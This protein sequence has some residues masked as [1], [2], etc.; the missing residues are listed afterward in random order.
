MIQGCLGKEGV[1]FV[2]LIMCL[3]RVIWIPRWTVAA[4]R[5]TL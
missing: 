2:R 3:K 4:S 1:E 5:R